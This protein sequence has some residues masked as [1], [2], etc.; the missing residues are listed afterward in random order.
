MTL[1]PGD[2][3]SREIKS[4]L[5]YPKEQIRSLHVVKLTHCQNACSHWQ[6][7]EKWSSTAQEVMHFIFPP[8]NAHRRRRTENSATYRDYIKRKSKEEDVNVPVHNE[9]I[10]GRC[11]SETPQWWALGN[12]NEDKSRKWRRPCGWTFC[13]HFLSRTNTRESNRKVKERKGSFS[14]W[15]TSGLLFCMCVHFP[16]SYLLSSDNQVSLAP[17]C[18][19]GNL[20][21]TCL[22][23]NLQRPNLFFLPVLLLQ[24]KNASFLCSVFFFS[25]SPNSLSAS[26]TLNWT[27][28][29]FWL[30]SWLAESIQ[31]VGL[32][33]AAVGFCCSHQE[34]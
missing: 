18:V 6:S 27:A 3:A 16:I 10:F 9:V 23:N 2:P 20:T 7:T 33:L 28:R 22:Y 12:S 4:L 31:E 8:S 17:C 25:S 24:T 5:F 13:H 1:N 34:F 14:L 29:L 32:W 21:L 26:K 15:H 11:S 30:A 19:H